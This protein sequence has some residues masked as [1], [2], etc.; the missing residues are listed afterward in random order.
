M[1]WLFVHAHPDD[2]TLS[3]G[4]IISCLVS[5]G[6]TCSVLTATRGEMGEA[7]PGSLGPGQDL[8]T[9]RQAERTSAL[10]AL[11]ADDAGWLGEGPNRWR[12]TETFTM[13]Q[14]RGSEA[15]D[16]VYTDSG[17]SW[18]SPI[19]AGPGP[20]SGQDSL[21]SAD[22]GEVV[23]DIVASAT[24]HGAQA[25][26]SYDDAGGYGHPDHVRCHQATQ[27]AAGRLGLPFFEI[28]DDPA[29]ADTWYEAGSLD[30]L[31]AVHRAYHTQ[32]TV[33]I[34][35]AQTP[36]DGAVADEMVIRHVGGQM[37]H[38]RAA[39]GLHLAHV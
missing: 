15:A 19:L 9:V 21:C 38:I 39:A 7:V 26:V 11:G 34:Q 36:A 3:T 24:N 37:D 25:L 17:M 32:F 13:T 20:A 1:R 31:L 5:Q 23:L 6:D 28:V 33:G 18:I 4:A 35:D 10:A 8:V 22:L 29:L 14:G 12:G 2:E 27:T 30:D 16:R